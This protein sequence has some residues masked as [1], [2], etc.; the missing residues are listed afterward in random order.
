MGGAG[1]ETI[2]G[3]IEGDYIDGGEDADNLSGLG[4]NDT[5]YGD[6]GVAES[7]AGNDVLNGGAGDDFLDGGA[8]VDRVIGGAGV[9]LLFGGEDSETQ[10]ARDTLTGGADTDFFQ[11]LFTDFVPEPIDPGE[12]I[13]APPVGDWIADFQ[14]GTDYF[15][16]EGL[17]FADL[18][19]QNTTINGVSGTH[20]Y[21]LTEG[22]TPA[23]SENLAFVAGVN[24]GA[25]DAS[26]F[27]VEPI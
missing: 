22:F 7:L 9:D 21:V 17:E 24:R 6:F 11:L 20:I 4:G 5:I 1:L 15:L 14:N 13:I 19:F 16:L 8:G 26:D 18:G 25:F 12:P 2:R 27:V 23:Q 10:T 3:G